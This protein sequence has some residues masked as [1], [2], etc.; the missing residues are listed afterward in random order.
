MEM[1]HTKKNQAK[2]RKNVIK[3]IHHKQQQQQQQ[4]INFYGHSLYKIEK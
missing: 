2:T 3:T 4:C 1:K